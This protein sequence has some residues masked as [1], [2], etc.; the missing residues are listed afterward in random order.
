MHKPHSGWHQKA[1]APPIRP[2][3]PLSLRVP[4]TLLSLVLSCLPADRKFLIANAQMENCAIIYCNDGFCE[5]FGYSRVEVMQRPCTCDFLTGPDTTKSSIAQLTQALLGSEE[6]KLE[7]LY[8]RKD[9]PISRAGIQVP[10]Y[11]PRELSAG[12]TP[13]C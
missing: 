12:S 4:T 3:C 8:Y 10:V 6:C 5:M 2:S 9:N 1:Q 11:R 7:I 13:A